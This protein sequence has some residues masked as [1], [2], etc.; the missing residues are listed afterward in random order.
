MRAAF[1]EHPESFTATEDLA[2]GCL[3][4]DQKKRA[5][6]LADGWVAAHP[7]HKAGGLMHAE[8]T[9]RAMK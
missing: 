9:R 3:E 5:V 4:M 7:D 2:Y 8:I 6:E 1:V